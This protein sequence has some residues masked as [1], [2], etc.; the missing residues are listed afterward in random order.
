MGKQD[1]K[2]MDFLTAQF[3]SLTNI[4]ISKHCLWKPGKA[5]FK[6]TCDID[7]GPHCWPHRAH[8]SLLGTK[9]WEKPHHVNVGENRN[10]LLQV[11]IMILALM[12]FSQSLQDL[13]FLLLFIL[14]NSQCCVRIPSLSIRKLTRLRQ[15]P[16]PN[17]MYV[18]AHTMNRLVYVNSTL[19]PILHLSS[20]REV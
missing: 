18:S 12:C 16:T 15:F 3:V 19:N 9:E 11:T 6:V 7:A 20:L 4:C 5:F 13:P 17:K 10:L 14:W 2:A 1:W 8:P